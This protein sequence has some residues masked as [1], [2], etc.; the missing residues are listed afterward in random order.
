MRALIAAVLVA[1]TLSGCQGIAPAE[2]GPVVAPWN[3]LPACENEDGP[4]P[5]VW[6]AG[7]EGNGVGSSF[8]IGADFCTYR[9][10]SGVRDADFECVD[11]Y[12]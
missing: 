7:T 8:Y 2:S 11:A 12:K 1:A 4:G 9:I 3:S 6:D 10:P 5:C